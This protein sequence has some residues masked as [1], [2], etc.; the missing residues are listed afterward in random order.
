MSF[1]SGSSER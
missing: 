1:K